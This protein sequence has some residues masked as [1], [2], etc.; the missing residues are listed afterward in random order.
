MGLEKKRGAKNYYNVSSENE[1]IL[2]QFSN[3]W[4]IG[5]NV[6]REK[7]GRRPKTILNNY[8]RMKTLCFFAHQLYGITDIT[9][10][11]EDE[12]LTIYAS[13]PFTSKNSDAVSM[14]PQR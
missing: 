10:I 6:S 14:I 11:T 1:L 12:I 7:G 3:D 4:R 9:K 8:Q 2:E 5:K 13:I